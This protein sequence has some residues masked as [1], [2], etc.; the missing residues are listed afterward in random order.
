MAGD[1]HLPF[2][3]FFVVLAADEAPVEEPTRHPRSGHDGG[4]EQGSYEW[5]DLDQAYL[6]IFGEHPDHIAPVIDLASARAE[7]LGVDELAGGG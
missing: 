6:D 4:M 2:G 3:S 5:T 1:G 7:R